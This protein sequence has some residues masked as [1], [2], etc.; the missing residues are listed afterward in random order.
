[1]PA[2]EIRYTIRTVCISGARPWCAIVKGER[3]PSEG[4]SGRYPSEG[5]ALAAGRRMADRDAANMCRPGETYIA[6]Y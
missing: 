3:W 2:T 1:M 4:R 6:V 5:M